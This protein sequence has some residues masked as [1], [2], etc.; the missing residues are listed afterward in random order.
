MYLLTKLFGNVKISRW[1]LLVPTFDDKRIVE[2]ATKKTNEVLAADLSYITKDFRV[3]VEDEMAFSVE[4][5]YLLN[6]RL[7]ELF[8][9]PDEIAQ[10]KID[11]W[12]DENDTL[13]NTIDD[14]ASRI[15]NLKT[16]EAQQAFRHEIIKAYLK[17]QNIYE[18]LRQ[19]PMIYERI[20]SVKSQKEHYLTLKSLTSPSAN[21]ELFNYCMNDIKNAVENEVGGVAATTI[22]AVAFEAVADW[23][24]RCPLD[25]PEKI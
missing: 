4:R 10:H 6:A 14:K 5:E 20:R 24:I 18:E 25:F 22:E 9:N 13:V 23:I 12:I 11:E 7:S 2:H 8:I 1:I 19:Y 16:N 15:P 3:I 17:G 21:I